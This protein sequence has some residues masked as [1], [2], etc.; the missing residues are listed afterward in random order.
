VSAVGAR[1]F[2]EPAAAAAAELPPAL[3]RRRERIDEALRTHLSQGRLADVP[4]AIGNAARKAVLTPGKRLRPLLTLASAECGGGGEREAMHLAC[5]IEL[6][7]VGIALV[8]QA[9]ELAASVPVPGLA[10]V[11]S[12]LA[13]AVG[14]RGLC[15]GQILD[16]RLQ[17]AGL[18]D[19]TGAAAVEDIYARKT[20]ALMAAACEVGAL[21]AG[22]AGDTVDALRRFGSLLGLAFQIQDDIGDEDAD[23]Q[24]R[25]PNYAVRFGQRT[26]RE[27]A[28]ALLDEAAAQLDPL[29]DRAA[30]LRAIAALV[31]PNAP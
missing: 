27:R 26:A 12:C 31:S 17:R 3:V 18:D 21:G 19:A 16:L 22:A 15:G 14:G 24:R 30:S 13:G 4:A 23:R 7:H 29:G 10:R 9:F 28:R 6:I 20:G 1:P 11:I 8:A 25:R 5:S 2:R